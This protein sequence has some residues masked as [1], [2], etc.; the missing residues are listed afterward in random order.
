MKMGKPPKEWF[1]INAIIRDRELPERDW[2]VDLLAGC[3][4]QPLTS[5]ER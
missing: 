2:A 5:W 1:T 3:F 4:C